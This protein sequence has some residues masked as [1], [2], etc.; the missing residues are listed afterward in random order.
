MLDKQRIRTFVLGGIAGALAGILLA[1][2][3]GKEL[4]GSITSRA[5]EARERGRETYFEAHERMQERIAR[6]R[7]RSLRPKETHIEGGAVADPLPN[8]GPAAPDPMID[9]EPPLGARADPSA[10]PLRDASRDVPRP[11]YGEDL[12]ELRR[13]VRETRTRLRARLNAPRPEDASG[14]RDG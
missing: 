12:E 14:G 9:P 6:A 1:P 5:G 10:P 7:E 3:S 2:K 8:L 4:R 11:A 13:R